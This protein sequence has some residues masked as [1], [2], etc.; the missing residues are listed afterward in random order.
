MEEIVAL[1]NGNNPRQFFTVTGVPFVVELNGNI[2]TATTQGGNNITFG[3]N[4]FHPLCLRLQDGC[5]LLGNLQNMDAN[6]LPIDFVNNTIDGWLFNNNYYANAQ[7]RVT[8]I[9]PILVEA[10]LVT[11]V[12]NGNQWTVCLNAA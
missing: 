8:Y 9:V 11:A 4:L 1:F 5:M 7:R 6:N 10:L 12:A 2:L 3:L